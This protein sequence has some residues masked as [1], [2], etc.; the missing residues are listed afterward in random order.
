LAFYGVLLEQALLRWP[1]RVG[2]VGVYRGV[3]LVDDE[4]DTYREW[5]GKMVVWDGFASTPLSRRAAQRFGNVLFVI[6]T[7]DRPYI[8]AAAVFS[9]E[10][11]V[12][13]AKRTCSFIIEGVTTDPGRGRTVI[14]LKDFQ[15]FPDYDTSLALDEARELVAVDLQYEFGERGG[16]ALLDGSI[17][18]E[19]IAKRM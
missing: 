10:Q 5:I 16:L 13:F 6:H 12:L 11:E 17:G 1:Q 2:E 19:R 8:G 15:C 18:Q 7:R 4:I 14:E 3:D 9:R